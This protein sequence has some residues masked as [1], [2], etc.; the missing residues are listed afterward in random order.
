VEVQ[1]KTN[2]Q[3][4]KIMG[5]NSTDTAYAFG[6]LGS[7]FVDDGGAFT[8]PAG[9]VIVA[10]QFLADTTL[11]ALVADTAQLNDV[12]FFSHTAIVAAAHGTNAEP[13]DATQIFPKG[14]T[15]YGRWTAVTAAADGDG[16]IICYFG[17]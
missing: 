3:I 10:I 17:E 9:K 5:I 11:S 2:K 6:Q 15:I 16:G 13:T 12:G 1:I 8:P 7:G 14:L 4:N